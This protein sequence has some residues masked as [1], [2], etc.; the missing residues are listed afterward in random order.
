MTANLC[1]VIGTRVLRYTMRTFSHLEAELRFVGTMK[2]DELHNLENCSFTKPS[3]SN[4]LTL[5]STV[6]I[7]GYVRNRSPERHVAYPKTSK[8]Q[9]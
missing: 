2:P 6:K 1:V 3:S 8:I 5:I 9:V 7:S 4:S